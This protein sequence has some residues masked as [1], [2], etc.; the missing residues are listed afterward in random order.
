[1]AATALVFVAACGGNNGNNAGSTA[2]SSSNAGA[3]AS[4][5]TDS[6][7]G[8]PVTIR[9]AW[10][11]GDTRHEYT[12]KVVDMYE[13]QHK[14]VTIE[15]E[16]ANYDDYWKKIAP[17]AAAG[18]LPDIIQ[19]D[20]SYYS[21][22][23]GKKQLADL[24]PFFGKEI[25]VSNISDNA[26]KAG[27]YGSGN[28]GMNLGVNS[29]G[30]QYVPETLN[31]AGIDS[32]PDNWTWDDYVNMA[33]KAKQAGIYIDDG[34]RPEIFFAYYLRTKGAT[35]YNAD[36]NGLGYDDDSLFVD[37]FGRIAD[38][39]KSGA[40][41]SA[42]VKAQIKGVEDGF[43]VKGQQI[44][45]WQWSNQY[46]ALQKAVN[47]PM[48]IAPMV[49]PDMEKG[50]YLKPSMFF[51]I[52]ESSKVKSEAAKFINF[53]VNDV[54]ANKLILGERGVPVSSTVQEAIKPL[55]S[56]AQQQVFDYVSWSEQHSSPMD[57]VD[58]VGSAEIIDK[59][60]T[61]SEQLEYN[62][63]SVEDAAKSFRA[64]ATSILS[65]NK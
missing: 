15:V 47:K 32:I 16:Y 27:E 60:K 36:G 52:A 62:Q 57:P 6:D 56:P 30:F 37:Y 9:L 17:Q 18:E 55:L 19:I 21:Q 50:L 4:A 11:G 43:T 28:Y 29:L 35:L 31:K 54:E 24:T 65:K 42:D 39:T 22:Y 25:D 13:A 23:A 48:E 5:S 1:M 26:L 20:T 34:F 38:V 2:S 59:L 3:S 7:S 33:A 58:P 46:D 14:N 41:P 8:K 61:L 12:K 51:S 49:G 53:W 44:G 45:V 10:W 40:A 64:D 63:I